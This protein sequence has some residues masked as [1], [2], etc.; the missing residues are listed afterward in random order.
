MYIFVIAVLQHMTTRAAMRRL[1]EHRTPLGFGVFLVAQV[2]WLSIIS[3]QG[4]EVQP[5]VHMALADEPPPLPTAINENFSVQVEQCFLPVAALYGYDL[6]VTSG[7]RTPDEQQQLYEQGRTLPGDI[8]THAPA[9]K[10]IHNYGY[11][12]DVVDRWRGYDINWERLG[13]IAEYCGL[14]QGHDGD[15]AH[16]EYRNGLTTPEF[17]QGFRPT[18]LRLPCA[19]MSERALA[20]ESFTLAD[21]KACGAPIFSQ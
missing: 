12:V 4:Y 14:R 2:L 7:F 8:V 3:L 6:R 21:L 10:S 9:G 11:A 1:L 15:L 13:A 16:F 5:Y 19:R 17:E 18:P 20:N